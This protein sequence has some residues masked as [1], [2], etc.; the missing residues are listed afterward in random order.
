M[1]FHK[2]LYENLH[3]FLIYINDL[4]QGLLSDVKLFADDTSLF[5]IVNR[6]K[7]STSS[8]NR[9]LLNIQNWACQWN[10]QYQW[11]HHLL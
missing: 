10:G 5:S 7:T 8:L 6:A 9:D 11:A 2:A 3:F 1:V 4:S